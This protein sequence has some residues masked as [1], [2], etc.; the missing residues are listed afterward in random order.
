MSADESFRYAA[1]RRLTDRLRVPE[2]VGP[3]G[4]T[5]LFDTWT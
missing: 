2:S 5:A 4:G 1:E 3:N